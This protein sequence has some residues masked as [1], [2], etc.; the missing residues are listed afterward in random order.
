VT[1]LQAQG[2]LSAERFRLAAD[3]LVKVV[4]TLSGGA[5]RREA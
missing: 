4:S 5:Y 1:F 3:W 2:A